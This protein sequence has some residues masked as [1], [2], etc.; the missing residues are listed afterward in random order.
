[1]I[2]LSMIWVTAQLLPS[3]FERVLVAIRKGIQTSKTN[4][5]QPPLAMVGKHSTLLELDPAE[6]VR[7]TMLMGI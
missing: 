2:V 5:L 3:M 7:T 6:Q 1:M 4:L